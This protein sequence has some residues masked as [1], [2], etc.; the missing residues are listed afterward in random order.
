[1]AYYQYYVYTLAYP[2]GRVFY[3]GKGQG[4]RIHQHEKE[5]RQ[6]C[7]PQ[8][9]RYL[10]KE[11]AKVRVI[12]EIWASGGKVVKAKVFETDEEEE[13]N[14]YEKQFIA[15]CDKRYL[16]NLTKGGG[17]QF[18]KRDPYARLK[19]REYFYSPQEAFEKLGVS[20]QVWYR[21]AQA[22]VLHFYQAEGCT[23]LVLTRKEIDDFAKSIKDGTYPIDAWEDTAH[24]E[25]L[26]LW[27]DLSRS[28]HTK[29]A[30]RMSRS[31]MLREVATFA[32]QAAQEAF[33]VPCHLIG[34]YEGKAQQQKQSEPFW[35]VYI[36]VGQEE[37]LYT[38]KWQQEQC[39][40]NDIKKLN[41]KPNNP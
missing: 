32:L 41:E 8:A 15:Q 17:P 2:D 37:Y 33:S 12:K 13:A 25:Q 1:M 7:N 3:V 29:E 30:P 10:P 40:I 23:F 35:E 36:Q 19:Q 27:D 21:L 31:E 16:T 14:A 11:S 39:V 24:N 5:A 6:Y 38:V 34:S 18:S 4:D 26:S 28:Q 20:D 9:I 22:G